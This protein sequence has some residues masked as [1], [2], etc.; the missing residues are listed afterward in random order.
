MVILILFGLALGFLLKRVGLG[1]L[2]GVVLGLLAS[3][4]MDK[5]KK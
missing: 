4:M 3:G 1:L 2:I 5:R